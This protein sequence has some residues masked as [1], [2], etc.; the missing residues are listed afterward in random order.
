MAETGKQVWGILSALIGI[1]FGAAFA[2]LVYNRML[3]LPE[4]VGL[5]GDYGLAVSGNVFTSIL[6]GILTGMVVGIVL[7]KGI[8]PY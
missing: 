4:S 3:M 5:V 8:H 1:V 7:Y 6:V 2:Y